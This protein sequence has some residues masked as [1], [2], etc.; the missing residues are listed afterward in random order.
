MKKLLYTAAFSL[1]FVSSVPAALAGGVLGDAK[2]PHLVHSGA[3]PNDARVPSATHHF[4]VHVQ[5]S[6]LS[7]LFIDLPEDIKLKRGIEVTDQSG[8]KVD[9]TVFV[10]RKGASVTFAQPVPSETTLTVSMKGVQTPAPGYA[11]SWRYPI[12]SRS[13]GTNEDVRIG[14]AQI[15]TYE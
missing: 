10:N 9:A 8:Q 7:Q 13:V 5:G 14:L 15:Q 1:A 12:Y 2:A 3:H 6:E 4:E 11:R